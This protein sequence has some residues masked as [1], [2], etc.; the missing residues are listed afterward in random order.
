MKRGRSERAPHHLKFPIFITEGQRRCALWGRQQHG[1]AEVLG[2]KQVKVSTYRRP[3]R[4]L[5]PA[6][7]GP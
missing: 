2:G 4:Q 5:T 1:T 6:Y 3:T 7:R